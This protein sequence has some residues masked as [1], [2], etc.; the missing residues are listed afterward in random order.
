MENNLQHGH[1]LILQAPKPEDFIFGDGLLGD[2]PIM[3]DGQWSGWIPLQDELQNLNG[4]EPY[5]CVSFGTL[6]CIETLIR[7]EFGATENYSDR[8]LATA[9]GTAAKKG[10][11]PQTIAQFLKNKGVVE[12]KDYPFDGT[13]DSFEKFYAPL[14]QRLYMLALDFPLEYDFGYSYV[15]SN[16][17]S[18]MGALTYSPV[19]FSVTAWYQDADGLYYRPAGLTDAHWV[20]CYGYVKNEYWKIYDSYDQTHKKVRWN[21]LPMQAMRYTLHK[22]IKVESLWDT[23]VKWFRNYLGF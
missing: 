5:A 3:P 9:T 21:S 23:W 10:N 13:I 2:A 6:N 19:G 20:C 7:Q 22:N 17:E 1:G 14:A 11:S 15:P 12:E 8:F 18:L 16:P 4:I